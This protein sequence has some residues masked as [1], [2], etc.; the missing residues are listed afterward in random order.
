MTTESVDVPN[1]RR[2]WQGLD[3]YCWLV[4]AVAALGWLF[5]TMD[6]NLFTLV[7]APS[8]K[9]LILRQYPESRD[10]PVT[11]A[12]LLGKAGK[13]TQVSR[14]GA[15]LEVADG[16]G[17][18]QVEVQERAAGDEGAA[19]LLA[20]KDGAVIVGYD[21]ARSRFLVEPQ[22]AFDKKVS[23]AGG[24]L[25]SIFLIGWSV[26]GFLFG[27][28]GDKI[29]RTGTMVLTILIYA[30]FTGLSALVTTIPM[31]GAMRF[32]T[33]LGVGGEWAAGAALVAEVFPAYA[34]PMALGSLQAL[35][36]VGNMT[37][38]VITWNLGDLD[39]RWRWAYVI[40]A[41][42]ALLVLWIRRS[43]REPERWKH[44]KAEEA[45]VGRE[46]GNIAELFRDPV[47]RAHTIAAVLMATA[48]VGALWG[49]GFFSTDLV[50]DELTKAGQSAQVVGTR[51][52]AMFFLQNF[53]SFFGIMFFAA[54]SE[55]FNRRTAFFLWFALAWASVLLFF[56]GVTGRGAQAFVVAAFL[57]PV[58]GFCTLGPFSGYTVYFP[59]LFPTRLR[60]TGCGFCYNAARILAAVAPFALAAFK[61]K[62][63]FAIAATLVSS[64]YL[65]GFLGTWL[66]PET[67]GKPLPE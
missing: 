21:A 7:R 6:Q 60:T 42:P 13:V 16:G 44:A 17:K 37:A 2:W 50:R 47:L 20:P 5:D 18:R 14:G 29:G 33:A 24:L 4:L 48:G 62:G 46:L 49:V 61:A 53:G 59:E 3:R 39:L 58:M 1:R 23:D 8:S 51:V 25:T 67:R 11:D 35:S 45:A 63:E 57:A 22:K 34:R 9:E 30:L 56:W 55:R 40:G 32:L 54:F 64:I 31:Y 43:V 28:L 26:G 36:A 10:L 65:L 27:I 19:V 41:V 52:S 66:A 12:Q 38:A 15:R